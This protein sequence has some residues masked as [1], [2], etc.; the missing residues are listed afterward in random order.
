MKIIDNVFSLQYKRRIWKIN[1]YY[2][3]PPPPLKKEY[4]IA[5]H[6]SVGRYVDIP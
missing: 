2:A 5:L 6:M 1:Y 3:P 4:H